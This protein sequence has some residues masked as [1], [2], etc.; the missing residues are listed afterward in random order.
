MATALLIA[1]GALAVSGQ[2]KQG[3]IAESQGRLQEKISQRNQQALERQAT[4]EKEASKLEERRIARRAR[5]VQARLE[6]GQAKTGISPAGATIDAL[7]DA[8]FQFS[9]DRNLTLRSGLIRARELQSK[10]RLLAAEGKFAKKI[11]KQQKRAMF[12]QAFGTGLMGA[13]QLKTTPNTN[14]SSTSPLQTQSGRQSLGM[15]TRNFPQR[16]FD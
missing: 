16:R 12:M 6:V 15:T 9:L 4:A 5:L 3:Q 11:G 13:S 1:G 8:A 2:I 7:A 10:G 14:L